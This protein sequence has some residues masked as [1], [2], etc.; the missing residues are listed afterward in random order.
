MSEWFARPVLHVADVQRSIDFYIEKLGF[1]ESWR[2]AED[3][4][5]LVAQVDRE[6]CALIFSSQWPEKNGTGRMFISLDDIDTV[7]AELETRGAPVRDG[8]WGYRLMVIEDP[9]GNAL[10]FNYPDD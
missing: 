3:G 6:G 2:F 7:R 8:R 4:N 10:Y 1:V 9:D 5:L